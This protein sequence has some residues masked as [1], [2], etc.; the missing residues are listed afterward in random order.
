MNKLE[1]DRHLDLGCGAKPRNPYRRAHLY[2]VDIAPPSNR[3]DAVIRGAN[4]SL[5]PI[6]FP[7]DH[8][9]SVSAY[10]FFEH[11]PRILPSTQEPGTRFPFI[12]LMNEVWRVL[13]PNG[14]LYAMTPA[15]PHPA[16][17]QDPTHVNILSDLSH[18]YF[19]EPKLLGRMYGFAG[20]FQIVRVMRVG[21]KFDY[22]PTVPDWRHRLRLKTRAWRGQDS[23][24]IWE[25]RAIKSPAA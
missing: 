15:Y 1:E 11:I 6:P 8:F 7:D 9:A 25:F 19:T 14:L 23:H 22:E 20:T 2:G 18:L 4:L 12:E 10:D 3:T 17:F 21:P 24:L 16:A 13:K 5:G